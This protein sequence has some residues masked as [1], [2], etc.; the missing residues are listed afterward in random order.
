MVPIKTF[1][2]FNSNSFLTF[3]QDKVKVP[4]ALSM[5]KLSNIGFSRF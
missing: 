3:L 1:L 4:S 2:S 5:E